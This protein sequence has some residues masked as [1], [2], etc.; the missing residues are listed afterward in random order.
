MGVKSA[1]TQLP[2]EEASRH[3]VYLKRKLKVL[4]FTRNYCKCFPL[5]YI[6][7]QIQWSF[8]GPEL[9]VKWQRGWGRTAYYGGN[10][11]GSVAHALCLIWGRGQSARAYA[12]KP[13]AMCYVSW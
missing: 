12:K 5:F 13:S 10:W 6:T 2:L 4:F 3:P 11:D 9:W 7:P 8:S 1:G